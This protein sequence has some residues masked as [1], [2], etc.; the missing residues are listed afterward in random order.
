MRLCFGLEELIV[1]LQVRLAL[2]WLLDRGFL[3]AAWGQG[4]HAI[5]VF[6]DVL[7]GE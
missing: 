6:W 5:A 4:E 2:S 1:L 3:L 7:S